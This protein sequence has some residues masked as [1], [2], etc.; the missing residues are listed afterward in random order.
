MNI[1]M[2]AA[3]PLVKEINLYLDSLNT[4]E[5]RAVLT[6]V[7]AIA[8]KHQEDDFWKERAWVDDKSYQDEMDRRFKELKTGKVKGLTLDELE[9]GAR[10]AYK[11]KKQKKA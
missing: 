7:K 6:V 2:G 9:A 1:F 3:K 11:N 5:Q 8:E 4:E 10:Q